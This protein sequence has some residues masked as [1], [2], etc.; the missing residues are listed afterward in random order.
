MDMTPAQ[1]LIAKKL[2]QY[3]EE[4]GYDAGTALVRTSNE[5]GVAHESV[6]KVWVAHRMAQR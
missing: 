6:L 1:K 2:L 4:D 3:I 5:L